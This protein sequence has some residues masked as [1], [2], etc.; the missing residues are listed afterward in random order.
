MPEHFLLISALWVDA[1]HSNM[2]KFKEFIPYEIW[3]A[4]D[5]IEIMVGGAE[6]CKKTL[7]AACSAT[8]TPSAL[9]ARRRH[10]EGHVERYCPGLS[11]KLYSGDAVI[12][13]AVWVVRRRDIEK[14]QK[15]E[16][17]IVKRMEQ[18]IIECC[19]INV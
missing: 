12:F 7:S 18:L 5:A 11:E 19:E 16:L 14:L 4:M 9:A 15:D 6:V 8:A 2:E 1:C 13:D 3:D 17:G 10:V